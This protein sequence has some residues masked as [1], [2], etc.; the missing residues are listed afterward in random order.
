MSADDW[1]ALSFEASQLFSPSTPLKEADLFA[2]RAEQLRK[3]L[4]ATAE[5]GKHVVLFGEPGVGKT[6]MAKLFGQLFPKT[7][8]HIWTIREQADPT[9]NFSSLWKKAF[10][11]IQ[12]QM[13]RDDGVI[14]N[15]LVSDFYPDGISPDDVRRELEV[16]FKPN[17]IP[18]I[19][20]D[21]FD[22]I[23]DRATPNLMANTI[24]Y[25]S[26]YAV[27]CTVILVGVADNVT[28]I[29]GEH[30]SVLRCLEQ[31]PMPRM[32][33]AESREIIEKIVPRLGMKIDPD[34]LWKIVNLARGL[35]S[36]VHA[37][38]QYATQSAAHRRSLTIVE[39]DIDNAIHRVLEKSQET[40]QADYAK[41]IQSNRS[42]N[43]YK[44]VLLACALADTDERGLFTPLSVCKPLTRILKRDR[45]VEISVFQQHLHKFITQDRASILTRKGKERSFRYRFTEPMMQPFV[46][47]KGIDQGFVDKRAIEILSFPEQRS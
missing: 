12:I 14:E 40:V 18:I 11:D 19:I 46:I 9:D 16:L 30:A 33:T 36:Y 20:F 10:R 13:L 26:D 39:N 29:I 45:Q 41:A 32:K 34:A 6:S 1:N 27:N 47:M 25:L 24:K 44:E 23:V 5:S 35:P 37:L 38:G 15:R 2:G 28:E 8:R 4:D 43:L 42:D 7:A 31:I 3:M 17:E 22:K 21:E